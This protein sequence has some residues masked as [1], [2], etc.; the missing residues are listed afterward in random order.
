MVRTAL[1]GTQI[2]QV[3]EVPQT[4][5]ALADR[6]VSKSNTTVVARRTTS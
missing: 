5:N 2:V 6:L 4:L 1:P 3:D